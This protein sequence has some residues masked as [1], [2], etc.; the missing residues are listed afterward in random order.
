RQALLTD[1]LTM[2]K[3]VGLS[4]D[5]LAF[6]FA[7]RL[8]KTGTGLKFTPEKVDE[9]LRE[10]IDRERLLNI[11]FGIDT[12]HD[13]LPRRFTHE[14]LEE[15]ASKGHVVPIEEMVREYYRLRGWDEQGRPL[16]KP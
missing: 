5:I 4:M 6:E 14:P 16:K 2:C 7:A 13:T 11:D 12:R 15:G 3:N 8:L 10:T 1:C 9:A